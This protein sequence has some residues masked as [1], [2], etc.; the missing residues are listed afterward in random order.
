MM[1]DH[2]P[3]VSGLM[4]YALAFAGIVLSAVAVGFTMGTWA[5]VKVYLG[6]F[7]LIAALSL[8]LAYGGRRG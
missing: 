6:G 4:I 1:T 5:A 2:R 7:A 3:K 8:Y